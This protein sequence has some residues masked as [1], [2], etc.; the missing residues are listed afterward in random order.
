MKEV[1]I[2]TA[3]PDDASAIASVLAASF[4]EYESLYTAAAY[5]ATTLKESGIKARLDE[6]AAWIAVVEERIVGTVSA[7]SRNESLYI[8][9]MAILPQAR[10][11]KI[12]HRLLSEIEAYAIAQGL[13][14]LTLSTTP[15]LHQAIRLYKKFGF[16]RIGTGDLFGTPLITMGKELIA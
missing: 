5:A 14:C 7:V 4:I 6:G 10:G 11:H 8:R 9:G 13:R 1:E 15:F 2:R 3:R 12:G 16:K